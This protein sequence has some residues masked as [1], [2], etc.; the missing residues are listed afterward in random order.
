MRSFKHLRFSASYEDLPLVLFDW[1]RVPVLAKDLMLGMLNLDKKKRLTAAQILEHPWITQKYNRPA[2]ETKVEVE[3]KQ[4]VRTELIMI[5]PM[6]RFKA[7]I[8]QKV[9]MN[10]VTIILAETGSA[11][12]AWRGRRVQNGGRRLGQEVG[13]H[14]GQMNR[15][16]S[17]SGVL[18]EE[19]KSKG[20]AALSHYKVVILDEIH[21]S[22]VLMSATADFKRYENYFAE[23]GETV[24][25]VAV[26]NLA[27]K[28]QQHLF[29]CS[30][31]YLDQVVQQ[32]GN[33]EEHLSVMNSLE[34]NPSPFKNGTDIGME[35]QHLIFDLIA[36]IHKDEPDRKKGILVFLPTYRALEEQWSPLTQRA[37]DVEIFVL[38]SSIDIDQSLEAM[39]AWFLRL[40]SPSNTGSIVRHRLMPLPRSVL[41]LENEERRSPD[42]LGVELTAFFDKCL[43]PPHPDTVYDALESLEALN[44]LQRDARGKKLPTPYGQILA[45]LPLSLEASM[46]VMEGCERE[47]Q[48]RQAAL[49]GNLCAFE[50]WQC[51]LKRWQK[52]S[53][54]FLSSTIV[55]IH[56]EESEKEFCK[57]HH[58]SLFSLNAVAE[59]SSCVLEV[60]HRWR[61]LLTGP[62]SYYTAFSFQHLCFRSQDDESCLGLPYVSNGSFHNENKQSDLLKI[63]VET[64][65][66]YLEPQSNYESIHFP[67]EEDGKVQC[68]YFRRGFCAK[69]N[70][71]EFSHSVSS[72]PAV[73]KFFLSGDGCRYGAHCR[74]KH[75]SDV[76]RWD[77][78]LELDE[79]VAQ[80][81]GAVFFHS[82]LGGHHA[83]FWKG[84]T[85]LYPSAARSCYC[86]LQRRLSA[87]SRDV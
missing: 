61:K 6:R 16:S 87:R 58:L 76:P 2:P 53:H 72:T 45:S 68:V 29:Q 11:E 54:E 73:C 4:D 62:P 1:S 59:L 60:M 83:S 81:P 67:K 7:T 80:F 63:I 14:I 74:Y 15:T 3:A 77:N 40:M 70:G 41:E 13:F 34:Q 69:G 20:V 27:S 85:V 50:F 26:S 57:Q 55:T 25:K 33:K 78:R 30:V 52:L 71:C 19:I 39:E 64:Q 75:D 66:R 21:E 5:M 49:L 10:R 24:E 65:A 44:A 86:I 22:L 37:L 17:S 48:S 9:E 38:H 23:L 56:G 8:V 28:I 36:H 51:V 31:K 32:L 79:D 18:L 42:C 35:I 47:Q 46:L 84:G 43:N 82:K 12:K